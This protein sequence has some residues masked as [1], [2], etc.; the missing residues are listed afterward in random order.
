MN[1]RGKEAERG[2]LKERSAIRFFL[3]G[4]QVITSGSVAVEVPAANVAIEGAGDGYFSQG[5]SRTLLSI[6]VRG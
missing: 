6:F 1:E 5:E 2:G 4:A 3:L